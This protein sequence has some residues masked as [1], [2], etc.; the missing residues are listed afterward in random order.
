M[1]LLHREV[2]G[3]FRL[4]TFYIPISFLQIFLEFSTAFV[5][6]DMASPKR[7]LAVPSP[8]RCKEAENLTR[9]ACNTFF[10]FP[11]FCFPLC[12]F[13]WGLEEEDIGRRKERKRRGSGR[14]LREYNQNLS[15]GFSIWVSI[16]AAINVSFCNEIVYNLCH[17]LGT[18][19]RF[20]RATA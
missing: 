9:E 16:H 14:Q 6:G 10:L 19:P 11:W 18:L 8:S 15:K 4:L 7:R 1:L 13:P 3:A 12:L 5:L 17:T 20:I 2:V